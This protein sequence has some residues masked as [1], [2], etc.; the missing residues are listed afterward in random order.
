MTLFLWQA[1]P[2][3]CATKHGIVAFT[4]KYFKCEFVS[5]ILLQNILFF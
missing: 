2:V 5:E 1:A 3:Y 4:K